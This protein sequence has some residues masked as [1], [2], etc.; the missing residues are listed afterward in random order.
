MAGTVPVYLMG[1]K[2]M[3]PKEM[4]AVVKNRGGSSKKF[5]SL[6]L[7][8]FSDCQWLPVCVCVVCGRL[9]FFRCKKF[10]RGRSIY[11]CL[12]KDVNDHEFRFLGVSSRTFDLKW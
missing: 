4:T 2:M 7:H 1:T 5:Y 9:T 10:S 11:V 3:F 6:S 12:E 8:S